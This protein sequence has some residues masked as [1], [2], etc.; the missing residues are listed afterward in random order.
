MSDQTHTW[1]W[2]SAEDDYRPD[3]MQTFALKANVAVALAGM[4]PSHLL[5]DIA[6]VVA[7]RLWRQGFVHPSFEDGGQE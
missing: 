3:V 7:T 6:L 5:D 1:E 4:V 2:W